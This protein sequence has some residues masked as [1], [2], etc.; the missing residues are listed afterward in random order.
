MPVF[1]G[2][3][4]FSDRSARVTKFWSHDHIYNKICVTWWIFVD[5]VIDINYDVIVFIS[6]YL[7]RPKVVIFADI[8][9]IVTMFIKE[10]FKDSKNIKSI[11]TQFLSVLLNIAKFAD[12]RWEN[13]DVTRNQ[14][15]YHVIYIFFG[16]SLGKV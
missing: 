10:L 14:Q 5:E 15:V 13:A 11:E 2:Y 12:F 4:N 16:S 7:R 1:W 6:K 3:D 8:S 9:K